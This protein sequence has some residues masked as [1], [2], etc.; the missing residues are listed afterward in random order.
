MDNNRLEKLT[1]TITSEY[2]AFKEF[3]LCGVKND[4]TFAFVMQQKLKAIRAVAK[5]EREI[6]RKATSKKGELTDEDFDRAREYPIEQ[7]VEMKG[8][9]CIAFC[10]E[11]DS[12]SMMLTRYNRL[13]CH[14]CDKSFNPIDVLVE[15]DGYSFIEAVKELTGRM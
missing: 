2:R 9:R 14:V 7:L 10:H 6:V 5:A 1:E 15:R 13:K 8:G 12:Y 11:S 3:T 4:E